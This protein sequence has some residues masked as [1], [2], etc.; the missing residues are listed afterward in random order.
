ML[1]RVDELTDSRQ[2]RAPGA[3][4]TGR[5]WTAKLKR[6]FFG[7]GGGSERGRAQLT[8]VFAMVF[9]IEQQGGSSGCVGSAQ[10]GGRYEMRGGTDG[11][12]FRGANGDGESERAR[13]GNQVEDGD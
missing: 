5:A 3:R 1:Q 11:P 9:P 10:G 12:R 6:A 4:L 8:C 13:V 2:R 7:E